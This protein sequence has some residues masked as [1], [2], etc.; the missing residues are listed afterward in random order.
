MILFTNLEN[1]LIG[2]KKYN[3]KPILKLTSNLRLN[4]DFANSEGFKKLL[5]EAKTNNFE[6]TLD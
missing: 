4:Q 1:V 3:P 5:L 2:D 6:V